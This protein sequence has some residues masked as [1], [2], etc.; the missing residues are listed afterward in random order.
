MIKYDFLSGFELK[1]ES[2]ERAYV[3][4]AMKIDEA[5]EVCKDR[6]V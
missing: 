1:E 6:D 2:R 4:R 3:K 5:K